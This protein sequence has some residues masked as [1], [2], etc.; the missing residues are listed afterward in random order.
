MIYPFKTRMVMHSKEQHF[1]EIEHTYVLFQICIIIDTEFPGNCQNNANIF[2]TKFFMVT[3]K[4]GSQ[5]VF[6]LLIIKNHF[7]VIHTGHYCKLN[8]LL[9]LPHYLPIKISV[10]FTRF[11]HLFMYLSTLRNLKG[12][13]IY[14]VQLHITEKV[15]KTSILQDCLENLMT[16]FSQEFR[17]KLLD[18]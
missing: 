18:F 11:Y 15:S 5:K 4:G 1:Q 16:I 2:R 7:L 12:K 9:V 14:I 13:G 10:T 17:V 3:I 6:F 8:V